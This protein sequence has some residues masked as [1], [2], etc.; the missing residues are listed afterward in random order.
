MK[1]TRT[2]RI[3]ANNG[4]WWTGSCFGVEQVAEKYSSLDDLPLEIDGLELEIH[5]DDPSRPD[6]R[7]YAEG[8]MEAEAGVKMTF[9]ETFDDDDARD[10]MDEETVF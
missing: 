1:T 3:Q 4:A 9:V 6:A 5:D 10:M 2:Y 8:Q 7:Y